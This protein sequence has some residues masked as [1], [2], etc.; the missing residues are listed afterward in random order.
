MEGIKSVLGTTMELEEGVFELPI[1]YTDENGVTHKTFTLGEMTGKTEEALLHKR[2]RNRLPHMAGE[3]VYQVLETL[4]TLTK[5]EITRELVSKMT[6][7]DIDYILL[8]NYEEN[9]G[10]EFHNIELCPNCKQ[11]NDIYLKPT[12]I[13]VYRVGTGEKP[14][15][16]V[17][18]RNGIKDDEGNRFKDLKIRML[19]NKEQK[20]LSGMKDPN[21]VEA[22]NTVIA[23]TVE[24]VEG[25]GALDFKKVS[26]MTTRDRKIITE[27]IAEMKLGFDHTQR[28]NCSECDSPILTTISNVEL[29]GK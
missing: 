11:V 13:P 17:K 21:A 14:V 12:Q 4:G 28:V 25:Y 15:V 9:I 2:H 1:G 27:K 8:V 18:L 24:N 10:D 7:I 5:E 19:T 22:F 6:V 23:M 3:L 29:L 16:E 26:E 20:I